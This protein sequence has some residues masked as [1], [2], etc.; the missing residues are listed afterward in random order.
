MTTE[1]RILAY[2]DGSLSESESAELMHQLSV[3]P[4]NRIIL[5]QHIKLSE[6]TRVAQ[7]P[8]EVPAMLESSLAE[9]L[10]AILATSE[11]MV[12][13]AAS[14]WSVSSLMLLLREYPIR[15]ALGG[16]IT[17]LAGGA[18]Y[19]YGL[20]GSVPQANTASKI[21]TAFESSVAAPN[22]S[23]QAANNPMP[24]TIDRQHSSQIVHNSPLYT[25]K[26]YSDRDNSSASTSQVSTSARSHSAIA[27]RSATNT[28]KY[29]KANGAGL[30]IPNPASI[31]AE[32]QS[33]SVS[34]NRSESSSE[35]ISTPVSAIEA[36]S[37]SVP[38][39]EVHSPNTADAIIVSPTGGSRHPFS[40][41]EMTQ[42]NSHSRFVLRGSF[43]IGETFLYVPTGNNSYTSRTESSPMLGLD[44]LLSPSWSIGIESGSTM[45][46]SLSPQ[47][48]AEASTDGTTHIVTHTT[49]MNSTEWFTLA[50]VRY[51]FNPLDKIRYEV[52][53]GGGTVVTHLAS[54]MATL[55]A[56]VGYSLSDNLDIQFLAHYS[57]VWSKTSA[58]STTNAALV[59]SG[60]VA[61]K[62]SD[63]A[64]ATV[65]TPAL[66][67]RVG[68]KWRF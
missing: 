28:N 47:S 20:G 27:N 16:I 45:M 17:L 43:G 6:M 4:E 58:S 61:Y 22:N 40:L 10:P 64:A 34:E 62:T 18:L 37:M 39:A 60:P 31:F 41:L 44:Y 2:L 51:C 56:G 15:F 67:G 65:F 36:S 59:T 21:S 25:S 38:I 12:P 14:R 33:N 30:H 54:P 26:V 7:R 8:Y 24:A 68:L 11:R 49:T 3:S 1:E 13:V 42:D 53:L 66:T 46:L 32:N 48:S 57:G 52:S 63:V 35:N 5:E 29:H 55:Q 50:A 9:R 23:D 19:W